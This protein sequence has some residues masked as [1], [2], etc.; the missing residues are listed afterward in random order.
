[1]QNG[2]KKGTG[3]GWSPSQI[4]GV[5]KE[6]KRRKWRSVFCFLEL[7]LTSNSQI[8]SPLMTLFGL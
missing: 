8:Q 1:M 4:E 3:K 5:Q 2:V 6:K 7:R